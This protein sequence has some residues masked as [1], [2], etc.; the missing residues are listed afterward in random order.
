MA[1]KIGGNHSALGGQIL[2]QF[3]YC[4]WNYRIDVT[5]RRDAL[6]AVSLRDL[7]E[8]AGDFGIQP[9]DIAVAP[10]LLKI[11]LGLFKRRLIPALFLSRSRNLRSERSPEILRS[12]KN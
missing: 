5:L 7:L 8:F 3:S 2:R 6:V 12:G 11:A 10:R 9:I 4:I 1:H